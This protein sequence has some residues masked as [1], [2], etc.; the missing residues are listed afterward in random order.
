MTAPMLTARQLQERTGVSARW[1]QE[2]ARLGRVEHARYGRQLRFP[3]HLANGVPAQP[4][5]S[6]PAPGTSP[7][8][9]SPR[10]RIARQAVASRKAGAR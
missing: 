5:A 7:T 1:W 8:G 10:S 3:A 9:L 4:L 6:A 2:Q